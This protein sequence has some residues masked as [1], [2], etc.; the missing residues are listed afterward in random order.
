[1]A[2]GLELGGGNEVP[3]SVFME[4]SR[5]PDFSEANMLGLSALAFGPRAANPPWLAK[6]EKPLPLAVLLEVLLPKTPDAPLEAFAN[7]D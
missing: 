2:L 7:P 4:A 6:L 1:M 5:V 3:E